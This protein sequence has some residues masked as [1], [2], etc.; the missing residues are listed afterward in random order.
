MVDAG[1]GD[2]TTG[3]I[4]CVVAGEAFDVC[5]RSELELVDIVEDGELVGIVEEARHK[6]VLKTTVPQVLSVFETTTI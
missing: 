1:A 3:W 4:C 2:A 5:V 6:S